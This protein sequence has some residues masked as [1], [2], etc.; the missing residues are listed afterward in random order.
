MAFKMF[1]DR[2]TFHDNETQ[3]LLAAPIFFKRMMGIEEDPD[4]VC[5]NL[6][7]KL[8]LPGLFDVILYE[9]DM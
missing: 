9:L 7:K 6:G 3:L 5:W 4:G 1:Y 2:K 8:L